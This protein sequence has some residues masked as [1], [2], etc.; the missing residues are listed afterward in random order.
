MP[1][2]RRVLAALATVL[3]AT[4]AAAQPAGN[5]RR[6]PLEGAPNFRDLG[7]YATTD[8]RH[9]RWGQVY[10]SSDLAKLTTR[11]F[12]YL[13]RLGISVVC[14]FRRQ[15]ERRSAPTLWLGPNA[16]E[17]LLPP[18]PDRDGPDTLERLA[19]GASTSE[20]TA[21][22][23]DTYER[24]VAAYAPSYR[25][26]LR[27]ILDS[28]RPT[29]YHCTAGKDRTGLFSAL[30]LLLLGVPRETVFADYLLSNDYVATARQ[31]DAAATQMKTT[32]EAVR[33]VFVADRAYLESAL[34]A[35][36]RNFHSLD[37]YRRTE[38]GLSDQHLA[39]LKLRLLE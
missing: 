8:G 10:R 21:F 18:T 37:H 17:I 7:G 25:I 35:I 13:A 12:E 38:L 2:N 20:M 26:A 5:L 30:L 23:L 24:M 22:M 11:D 33:A 34:Q 9:V 29:L 32:P 3:A 27:R 36:D 4:L 31:V 6:L 1:A 28:D 19:A 15:D 39:R 14:D 16:P